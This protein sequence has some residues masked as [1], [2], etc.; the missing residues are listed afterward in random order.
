MQSIESLPPKTLDAKFLDL[1]QL[2]NKDP[3]MDNVQNL[4]QWIGMDA[5][6]SESAQDGIL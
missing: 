4:Q 2:V 1:V 3:S 6:D 5:E